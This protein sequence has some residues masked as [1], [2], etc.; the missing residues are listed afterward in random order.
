MLAHRVVVLHDGE[1]AEEGPT[2]QVL[3]NPQDDYT[4]RLI[5]SLPVPDPIE[6]AARRAVWT[7]RRTLT[8][9]VRPPGERSPRNPV[10]E[11]SQNTTNAAMMTIARH[12]TPR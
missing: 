11:S 5:A 2:A 12:G 3:G 7:R 4:K 1:V 8:R 10:C 6:Q 9:C